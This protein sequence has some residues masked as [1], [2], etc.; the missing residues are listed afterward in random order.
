MGNDGFSLYRYWLKLNKEADKEYDKKIAQEDFA[1]SLQTSVA[2]QANAMRNGSRQPIVATRKDTK[3]CKIAVIPGDEMYIGD[4]IYVF[5]EYWL[6]MELHTDEY[7]LTYGE[8]WMCNQ[9]F[10]YQDHSLNIIEKYAIMDDGSYSNSSDKAIPVTNNNFTCYISLDDESNALYVDKRLA[11]DVVFDSKGDPILEVGKIIWIDTRSKNFGKGSHLLAFGLKDDVY[12]KERD[13]QELMIC[14]YI[15]S[16]TDD[17][18]NDT[19]KPQ[20]SSIV[21]NGRDS[22]RIGTGRTYKA[23][24]IDLNGNTCEIEQDVIWKLSEPINGIS[25]SSNGCECI[26][27]V[28]LE[29]ELIGTTFCLECCDLSGKMNSGNKEVAVISFG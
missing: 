3:K 26:V 20:N 14:D 11:I 5:N 4:L 17:N 8:I 24:A 7:G 27:Q 29:D 12:N 18:S 13:N 1:E 23:V 19:E 22:I 25:I 21:I 28:S 16:V 10:K 15:D 2:Y 6:C 9:I